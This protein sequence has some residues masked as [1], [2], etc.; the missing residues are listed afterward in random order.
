[1]EEQPDNIYR[2]VDRKD[3]DNRR[4]TAIELKK[5]DARR[6]VIRSTVTFT[7]LMLTVFGLSMLL[8]FTREESVDVEALER[9]EGIPVSSE[10]N[11]AGATVKEDRLLRPDVRM[12]DPDVD[13][14]VSA[15]RTVIEPRK[16][17]EAMANMR[18]ADRYL[19]ADEWERAEYYTRKA[20]EIWPD[21][22]A[23][24]R[25]LGVIYTQRGQFDQAVQ[26][27]ESAIKT[28]PFSAETFNNLATA[29]MHR[30]N[31]DRAEE[32]LHTSI[33]IDPSYKAG[34]LNLGLLYLAMGEYG[35]AADYLDRSARD[36]PHEMNIRNNLGVALLRLGKYDEAR[37]HLRLI[38]ETEPDTASAYFNLAISYVLEENLNEA[39]IWIHRGA[40]YCSPVM[41]THFLSDSD[42]D[43]IRENPE[44]KAI[45]GEMYPEL[46]SGPE[47]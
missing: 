47:G 40:Q 14:S 8:L 18:M 39:L 19:R 21:M 41:L 43:A 5:A 15:S 20:L 28:D 30:G 24:Q 7:V 36:F 26:A 44:F 32:L 4:Q 27:L 1:M 6:R 46:P 2:A 23:A 34:Y 38:I 35:A 16:M 22:N 31:F 13:S 3:D 17:A 9:S 25:M 29:Y 33:Q 11:K 37:R 45:L 10:T 12:P 42:F